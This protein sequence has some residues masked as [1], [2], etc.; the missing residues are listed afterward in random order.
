VQMLGYRPDVTIIYQALDVF[1]MSSHRDPHRGNSAA[2][3]RRRKRTARQ[4]RGRGR[5]DG[6]SHSPTQ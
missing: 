4:G 6:G 2:S 1:A 5:L 3:V